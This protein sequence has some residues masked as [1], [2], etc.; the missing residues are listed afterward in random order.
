[1]AAPIL[2]TPRLT[3]RMHRPDDF[4]ACCRVW[5]DPVVTRFIGGRA[6][7]REEVWARM[8]RHAGHWQF[9]GF[10]YFAIIDATTGTVIGEAGLADFHR[11]LVPPLGDTPEAG[12]ALLP[13]YHGR[14]LAGEAMTAIL[15]WS[16]TIGVARTVCMIDPHNSPSLRL[17]GALGYAEYAQSVYKDTP[18]ILL[19]RER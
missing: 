5:A 3:L 2:T 16:K 17:A 13:H 12:W 19:E 4:E 14:G 18:I 6:S 9:L 11:D 15:D 7:T 1:M 8:L 10:G